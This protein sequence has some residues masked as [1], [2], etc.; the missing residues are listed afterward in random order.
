[1]SAEREWRRAVRRARKE[2]IKAAKAHIAWSAWI[3]RADEAKSQIDPERL[4]EIDN[5]RLERVRNA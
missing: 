5:K 1:M 3:A 2:A 4:A